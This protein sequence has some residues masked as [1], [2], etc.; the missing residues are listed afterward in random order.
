MVG[1]GIA[2]VVIGV[3]FVQS[4]RIDRHRYRKMGHADLP[5]GRLDRCAAYLIIILGVTL[6][7][8]EVA[9]YFL[10]H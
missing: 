9:H 4:E 1:Y 2:F 7:F 3:L 8:Y 6:T 5:G 10:T